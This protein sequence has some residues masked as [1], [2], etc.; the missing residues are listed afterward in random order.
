MVNT[1]VE[2]STFK[3]VLKR[4]RKNKI[5]LIS[6]SIIIL[7]IVI[8]IFAPVLAPYDPIAPNY[9]EVLKPP[10]PAHPFGTDEFGRDVFSRVI[11]GTRYAL[12]IGLGV[13][14]IEVALG[15]FLGLIAGYFGRWIDQVIMRIV[16]V[17]LSIPTLVL[18]LAFA[19]VLGGGLK[20]VILA[21]GLIMW[22]QFARLVRGQVLSIK[23]ELF[24]EAARALGI[25]DLKIM[26]K[27]IIPNALSPI[28]VYATLSI[29]TAILLSASLSFLGVGAQP[30]T[31]EWGLI[32]AEGRDYL[33][34]A[35]WISTF[36]GLAIM[37]LSLSFN[38]L[39]DSL[40][41]AIS[42]QEESVL[43]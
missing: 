33:S 37:I 36:P 38:I 22:T 19:A 42:M 9:S 26:L 15:V 7:T 6:A 11:Y 24:V 40:R 29:P 20:N 18:G 43:Q 30:P 28:I 13:V 12:L 31:P 23:E 32:V 21:A 35:W 4:L 10:S 3:I 39:G 34:S 14:A 27:H 1:N 8:A 17:F 2:R 41:D 16:D 25:S 5:A